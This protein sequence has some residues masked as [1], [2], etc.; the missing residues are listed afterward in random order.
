M[1]GARLL[2]SVGIEAETLKIH[3]LKFVLY[4]SSEWGAV[5]GFGEV[6]GFN[7]IILQLQGGSAE[8]CEPNTGK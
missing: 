5:G 4:F 6:Q 1:A 3:T 2:M 7:E 8:G